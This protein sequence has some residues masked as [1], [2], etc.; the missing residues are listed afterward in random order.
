MSFSLLRE[1]LQAAFVQNLL[2]D[3][4][5]PLGP[6]H[7]LWLATAA[8]AD[9]LGLDTVG[10]L[11]EGRAFD[12]VWLRPA[13]GS[14][15]DVALRHAADSEDAVAKLFALAETADVHRVWVGGDEVWARP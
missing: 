6:A 9:A 3:A 4:G 11:S 10:H 15:L 1:G 14:S 5:V 12:A 8:G 7:L 13:A 2:G